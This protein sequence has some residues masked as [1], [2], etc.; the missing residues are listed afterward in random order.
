M[1]SATAANLGFSY[2]YGGMTALKG[3]LFKL[4]Y[5]DKLMTQ[6]KQKCWKETLKGELGKHY[7][8]IINSRGPIINESDR[9][10]EKNFL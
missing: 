8:D 7:R 4:V 5:G 1:T 3:M 9:I 2:C 6:K 10:V